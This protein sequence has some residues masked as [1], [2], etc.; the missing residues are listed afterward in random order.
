MPGSTNRE[1]LQSRTNQRK[2]LTVLKQ[3]KQPLTIFELPTLCIY[4]NSLRLSRN[5]PS[6]PAGADHLRKAERI[7]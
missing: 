2:K 3:L 4:Q 7:R 6:T 5:G 1:T